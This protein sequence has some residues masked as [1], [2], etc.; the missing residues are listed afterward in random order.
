MPLAHHVGLI[1]KAA[2]HRDVR[3]PTRGVN[4]QPAGVL[5]PEN[6]RRCLG[7]DA[8]LGPEA[9]AEMPPAETDGA[10]EP[11]NGR[12]SMTD[13]Q[14]A[15]GPRH[16]VGHRD[17]TQTSQEDSIRYREALSPRVGAAEA[18]HELVAHGDVDVG[19]VHDLRGHLL[20]A[21]PQQRASR[22]GL[23]EYVQAVQI[24]A[25]PH[26]GRRRV[27]TGDEGAV[28]A[29]RLRARHPHDL[30]RF[31]EADDEIDVT[32]GQAGMLR[33]RN[34]AHARAGIVRDEGLQR[35]RRR[36]KGVVRECHWRALSQTRTSTYPAALLV[37]DYAFPDEGT[38]LTNREK[39]VSANA[40]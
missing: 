28:R 33:L 11:V 24:S 2:G 3:H 30:D 6:P 1:V 26:D 25:H 17:W 32:G 29:R 16:D 20:T 18:L 19:E 14:A 37:H 8:E 27:Q 21:D 4:E 9:L 13:R 35:R 36:G 39:L 38:D 34:V 31:R 40:T 10:C 5:E 7:R 12:E 15:P 23:Q 22:A